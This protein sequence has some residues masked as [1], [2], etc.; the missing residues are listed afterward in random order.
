[1]FTERQTDREKGEVELQL[2]LAEETKKHP[3]GGR[4]L[5]VKPCGRF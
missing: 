3:N 1:M 5:R 2:E 4:E